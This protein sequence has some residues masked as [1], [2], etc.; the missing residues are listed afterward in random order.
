[1]AKETIKKKVDLKRLENILTALRNSCEEALDGTW[2]H[3]TKEGSDA[4]ND[5]VRDCEEVAHE[6]GIKLKPYKK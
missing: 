4:F 1:M 6:L 3:S 2:N 5:M